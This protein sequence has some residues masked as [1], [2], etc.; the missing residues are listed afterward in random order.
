MIAKANPTCEVELIDINEKAVN[1]AMENKIKNLVKNATIYVSNLYENVK[2]TFDV[3]VS[4]PPIRA[5][6]VVV[7][8]VVIDA[9]NYLNSSGEIYLV[10]QKKQGAASLEKK[11]LEVFGNVEVVNKKNG[12]FILKSIKN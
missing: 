4:N 3:I 11:L 10:I 6:K 1:L 8:A 12:Y 5:G 2:N 9:Y 7:H